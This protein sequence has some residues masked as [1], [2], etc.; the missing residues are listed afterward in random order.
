LKLQY[1]FPNIFN[2]TL[3]KS[4]ARSGFIGV[5]QRRD[6][7]LALCWNKANAK[8]ADIGVHE[9]PAGGSFILGIDLPFAETLG[10]FAKVSQDD[11]LGN[12]LV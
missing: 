3:N 12:L 9:I 6:E 2:L 10:M 5:L 8:G 4:G 1:G 11:I 7:I